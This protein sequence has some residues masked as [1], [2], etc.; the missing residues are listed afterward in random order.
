MPCGDHSLTAGGVGAP[1]YCIFLRRYGTPTVGGR[2]YRPAHP[3]APVIP[4]HEQ[5]K[6]G[7]EQV[8]RELAYG[9]RVLV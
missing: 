8:W 1:R 9:Q 2:A 4:R 5:G 7:G 3:P 6:D